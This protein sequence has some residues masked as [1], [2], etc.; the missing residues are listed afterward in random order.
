MYPLPKYLSLTDGLRMQSCGY[1]NKRLTCT[2]LLTEK[3]HQTKQTKQLGGIVC[4]DGGS[5]IK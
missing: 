1:V 5:N 3:T 4:D 2:T